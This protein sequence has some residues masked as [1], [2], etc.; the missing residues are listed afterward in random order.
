MQIKGL[1]PLTTDNAER[2]VTYKF[3]I[4]AGLLVRGQI[5]NTLKLLSFQ[6]DIE[7]KLE[8]DKGWLGSLFMVRLEGRYKDI[9][10]VRSAVSYI[11]RSIG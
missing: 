10:A 2:V 8:E 3:S 1:P 7:L 5:R 9:M 11:V 4:E 6:H